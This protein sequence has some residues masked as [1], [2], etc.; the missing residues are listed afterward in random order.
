MKTFI[1]RK[2]DETRERERERD[3]EENY[4]PFH[5]TMGELH[6]LVSAMVDTS[7]HWQDP[8]NMLWRGAKLKIIPSNLP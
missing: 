3:E 8:G 5:P 7:L 4:F 2:N 6:D 1:G